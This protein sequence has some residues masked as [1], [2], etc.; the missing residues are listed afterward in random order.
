MDP[1]RVHNVV[2]GGGED[3]SGRVEPEDA[4]AKRMSPV[5]S[6]M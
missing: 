3:G 1:S 6:E 2:A 5:F 4:E